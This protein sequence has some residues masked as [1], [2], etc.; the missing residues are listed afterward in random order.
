VLGRGRG[1][2][3]VVLMEARET[4]LNSCLFWVFFKQT[5]MN[6]YEIKSGQQ[7]SWCE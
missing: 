3:V 6:D 1:E 4:F 2:V 5:I 7:N